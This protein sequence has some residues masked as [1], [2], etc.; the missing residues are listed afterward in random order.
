MPGGRG[1][2]RIAKVRNGKGFRNKTGE[3]GDL[4]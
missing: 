3:M 1:G 4:S 2:T